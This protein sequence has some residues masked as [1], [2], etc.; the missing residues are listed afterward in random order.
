[1]FWREHRTEITGVAD[2]LLPDMLLDE[3]T[4][5][6]LDGSLMTAWSF[7]GPDLET[8]DDEILNALSERF[9]A[10]LMLGTGW[11]IHCDAIRS[12]APGHSQG[13]AFPD[14]VSR[15]I[16]EERYQQFTHLGA[17]FRSEY[18]LA[19]T[20]LEPDAVGQ[21]AVSWMRGGQEW[22]DT[23]RSALRKFHDGVRA[24]EDIFSALFDAQRLGLNPDGTH[25]LLRYLHR[26]V[27]GEV[28]P[29]RQPEVPVCL[30]EIL[31]SQD[32]TDEP[33]IG[34]R[35]IR[36][37]AIDGFPSGCVP[38]MLARLDQLNI[39]YRWNSRFIAFDPVDGRKALDIHRKKW[40]AS[41]A[42]WKSKVLKTV[43]T[44]PDGFASQMEGEAGAARDEASG[45]AVQFGSYSSNVVLL[46]EDRERIRE[47]VEQVMRTI[48]N[49]GFACRSEDVNCI[50]AWLGTH[51][52]NSRANCRQFHLH[53]RNL[54]DLL[55]ITSVWQGR[56]TNPS[57]YMPPRSPALFC[58]V[59]TGETTYRFHPHV[60]DVG[61]LLMTGPQG[62]GKSV[63]LGLAAASWFQY[64]NA[65]VFSFDRDRAMWLLTKAMG[66]EHYDL[67]G[68]GG[69][70]AFCPLAQ[71]E[72]R[73]DRA[74]AANY[75]ADLCELSGLTVDAGHRNAIEDAIGQL[76]AGNRSGRTMTDFRTEV[77]DQKVK[78]AI[79]T[80]TMD[81][82]AGNL[83]DAER[84]TFGGM[85]AR[86]ICF[87][88]RAL[89]NAGD[90]IALP[91]LLYLFRRIEKRL[92]GSPTL[93]LLDE[94][95]SYLEHKVFREKIAEW[96]RSFRKFNACLWITTQALSDITDSPISKVLV[97]E[98]K[99]KVFLANA[100]ARNPDGR[101]AYKLLGLEPNEMTAV[102][103][104]IPKRG[105][106]VRQPEGRREINL[107]LGD[108]A[109]AFLTCGSQDQRRWAEHIMAT[110]P[111]AWREELLRRKELP[112]WA[113]YLGGL[114]RKESGEEN[115]CVMSA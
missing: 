73:E 28:H 55:P 89:L 57:H 78:D 20:Y 112:E 10:G 95:W 98:C 40:G 44:A 81:G 22:S 64:P 26:C 42:S 21:A 80:Y 6:Q 5:L 115:L 36:T 62:S 23:A 47:N 113:E 15:I 110:H 61:N 77:Q 60:Q 35:L 92:D 97:A 38:G 96:A 14:P 11:A 66:G 48:R 33:R 8:Q 105:Y 13:G 72:T 75:V 45:G 56:E 83:L 86:M 101:E 7:T 90:R 31:A 46:D 82:Q 49:L 100:E 43:D 114:R 2:L 76:A 85:S 25:E 65:Q 24:F 108:V 32:F 87:E 34:A 51:P 67:L 107:V 99:T 52:G 79:R 17:Q 18:F 91:V 59:T 53:T 84:D 71:L 94:A 70:M 39:E 69:S 41:V 19:L 27:T 37:V 54:A 29:V 12:P 103:K 88:T 74:W 1:M 111:E 4:L 58:A 109:K 68:E 50:E 104:L 63:F 9:N 16:H 102:A 3:H 106:Y 93:I 30:N